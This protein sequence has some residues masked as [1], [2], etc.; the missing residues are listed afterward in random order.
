LFFGIGEAGQSRSCEFK[1][2]EQRISWTDGVQV[3]VPER[4]FVH[5]VR[6]VAGAFPREEAEKCGFGSKPPPARSKEMRIEEKEE[7]RKSD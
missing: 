1:C 4:K 5:V 2:K 3:S 6:G 7:A